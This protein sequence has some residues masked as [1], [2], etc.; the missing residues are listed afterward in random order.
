MIITNQPLK[1]KKQSN[2]FWN[3]FNSNFDTKTA[4]RKELLV[5]IHLVT[6]KLKE[7][8]KVNKVLK[9]TVSKAYDLRILNKKPDYMEKIKS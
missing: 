8:E 5:Y 2:Q 7:D 6:N 1:P 4:N 9:Q 3:N